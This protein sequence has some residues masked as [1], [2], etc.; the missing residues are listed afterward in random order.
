MV[1]KFFHRQKLRSALQHL[2]MKQIA[3]EGLESKD[4]P[5]VTATS[6]T[7]PLNPPLSFLSGHER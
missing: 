4:L 5:K 7:S 3:T 1:T 2:R 6:K